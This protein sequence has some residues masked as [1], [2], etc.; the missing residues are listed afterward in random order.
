MPPEMKLIILANMN[1]KLFSW[2]F[3]FRKATDFRGGGSFKSGFL[4]R[5]CLNLTVRNYR[6][7]MVPIL[8]KLSK[9]EVTYFFSES[10]VMCCVSRLFWLGSDQYQYRCLELDKLVSRMTYILL[11]RT[12]NP[13]HWL[14]PSVLW[15]WWLDGRKG[16]RPVRP[17]AVIGLLMVTI[18]LELCSALWSTLFTR[19]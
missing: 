16:I 2:T 14:S 13:A 19:R 5:C 10:R 7:K 6:K 8:L 9:K 11:K 4:R 18:W 17:L 12:L 15:R 1:A 3:T